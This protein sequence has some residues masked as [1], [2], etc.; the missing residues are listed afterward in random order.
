MRKWL[1]LA[2]MI[3]LGN[4]LHAQA[5]EETAIRAAI[6]A[7]AEAWNRGDLDAFMRSYE[8]SP[9][10]AFIGSAVRRGWQPILERYKA[11]YSTKEQMGT[12]TFS[13]VEVRLID[14]GCGPAQVA[15][16]TGRFHL[17]R[18]ARGEAKKD[19]GIFSLVWRKGPRGWRIILDHTS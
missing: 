17:D 19:E 5:S 18:T 16:V 1:A 10:T 13:E 11:A 14:T 15:V 7:Q 9:E 12:L 6:Q 2:M 8:Q 4:L 3:F